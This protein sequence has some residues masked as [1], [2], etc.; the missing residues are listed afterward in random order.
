MGCKTE[1]CLI[2][3]ARMKTTEDHKPDLVSVVG[4]EIIWSSE[5]FPSIHI[6][7]DK[8]KIIAFLTTAEGPS[9]EDYFLVFAGNDFIYEVPSRIFGLPDCNLIKELNDRF[10]IICTLANS[11]EFK[12][13]IAYPPVYIGKP[14]YETKRS[15]KDGIFQ[16]L[17]NIF[18]GKIAIT[19]TEEVLILLGR[20]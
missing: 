2:G 4:N 1:C 8:I 10:G 20:K 13:E 18:T 6:A 17:K 15:E 19:M 3:I 14:F 9:I 7:I 16:K 12:S 11:T 5:K